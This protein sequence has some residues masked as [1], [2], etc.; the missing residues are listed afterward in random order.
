[1]SGEKGIPAQL[2]TC[3][4]V[5][6]LSVP[7][8]RVPGIFSDPGKLRFRETAERHFPVMPAGNHAGSG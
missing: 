1:M 7:V 8:F 4:E 5:S 3:H 6:V 2:L